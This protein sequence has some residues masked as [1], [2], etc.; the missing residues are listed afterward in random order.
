MSKLKYGEFSFPKPTARPTVSGYARGGSTS[1][2]PKT[3]GQA[4][5]AKVMGEFKRGDLHSGSAKGP[6][7]K[8][9]KQAIAIALSEKKAAG[10]KMGGEAW[11]GSK[12]DMEQDKKLAKKHGMS[13]SEW[14]KSSLDE[15]H[16]KQQSM[17][18]LKRGGDAKLVGMKREPEAI[19]KKEIALLKKAGAPAKIIK[20]EERELKM[21]SAMKKGGRAKYEEGGFEPPAENVFRERDGK[22]FHN[23]QEVS[24]EDFNKRREAVDRRMQQLRG[25]DRRGM[26]L[27]DRAKAAMGDLD[28]ETQDSFETIR[29]REQR[30]YQKG[31]KVGYADG[32]DVRKMIRE[33]AR[34]KAAKQGKQASEPM[35][36]RERRM[37]QQAREEQVDRQMREAEMQHYQRERAENEADRRSAQDALMYIPRKIG[38][39]ARSAYDA[40][41]NSDF[42]KGARNY[43]RAYQEGLGMTPSSPYEKKRG[44]AIHEDV[45]MDKNAIRQAVHKHEASM[46][47]GKPMTKLKKGGGVQKY[48]DGGMT[49][50]SAAPSEIAR[51]AQAYDAQRNAAPAMGYASMRPQQMQQNASATPA[52][53]SRL[54]QAYATQR[55]ASPAAGKL[56]PPPLSPAQQRGQAPV[57]AQQVMQDRK[58]PAGGM[59]NPPNRALPP[60]PVQAAPAPQRQVANTSG[61]GFKKGGATKKG[62]P[63]HSRTP[64]C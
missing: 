15:K 43:G 12:K 19:V 7:V 28:A 14:E 63:V 3:K 35:G 58:F 30:P 26:S 24:R 47:P 33:S 1:S 34:M 2:A 25:P 38:E 22:Y 16:D 49:D 11:E 53:M 8:N 18:G 50:N 17:K 5:V 45:A 44:G 37:V 29:K 46:H 10:Y 54:A 39:G 40:I 32:G 6:I 56:P 31:G 64:K 42:A 9:P 4:K 51:L 52:E 20:H 62:V 59:F 36:E 48:A 57:Y 27:R 23:N 55:N 61:L 60:R 13:Y 41:V 21:P